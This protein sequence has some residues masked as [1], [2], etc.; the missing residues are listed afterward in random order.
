MARKS[1]LEGRLLAVLSGKLNRRGVTAALAASSLILGAGVAIPVAMLRAAGPDN[2]PDASSAASQTPPPMQNRTGKIQAATLANL[3]WGEPVNG[4][5]MALA[6][7][8]ALKDPL[9]GEEEFYQLVVQNVSEKE[10]R[11]TADADAPNPRSMQ[12][13]EGERIVQALSDRDAQKADWTLAPGECGVLWMFTKE[14]RTKDGKTISSLLDKDLGGGT[15]YHVVVNMEVAKAPEG[16]WTGKL[17]TGETRGSSDKADAPEP[18]HKDARALYEIWQRH[19]RGCKALQ[20]IVNIVD[21][22][23]ALVANKP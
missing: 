10:I 22:A 20:Y 9:L 12:W 14:E 3:K 13:R 17:I 19:A 11:Y 6:F 23:K 7:P 1:A 21:V 15:R 5:R 2:K 18:K 4:L 16:A 8:P